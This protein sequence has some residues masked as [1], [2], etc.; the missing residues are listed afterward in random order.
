MKQLSPASDAPPPTQTAVIVPVPDTDSLVDEHRRHLDVAASWGVPAHV[1]VLYPFVEPAQ[2][3]GHLVA[4]LAAVFGSV[5]AFD[6]RFSQTQWF[7]HDVLWLNPEP[8]QPSRDLT[9][10]GVAAFHA[11][12]EGPAH[13]RHASPTPGGSCTSSD[14]E[15]P[16]TRPGDRWPSGLQGVGSAH[17][18]WSGSGGLARRR[19][20]DSDAVGDGLNNVLRWVLGKVDD[21][22]SDVS[23]HEAQPD[24]GNAAVGLLKPFVECPP[25]R[26]PRL[27][28]CERRPQS[29]RDTSAVY[30]SHW[31][32]C[33]STWATPSSPALGARWSAAEIASG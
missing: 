29:A 18:S 1:S 2:V 31:S 11:H 10:A 17:D 12:R 33:S 26:R 16:E 25:R 15:L 30:Q 14:S 22:D 5:A 28:A 4:T 7:G 21:D 9:A 19:P 13:R 8:A 32:M 24:C 20:V 3:D 6:C 27:P 23:D